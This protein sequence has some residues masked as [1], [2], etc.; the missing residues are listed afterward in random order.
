MFWVAGTAFPGS[1]ARAVLLFFPMTL[2]RA[3]SAQ[4]AEADTGPIVKGL[5]CQ[6]QKSGLPPESLGATDQISMSERS[7]WL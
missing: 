2:V 6:V 1:E 3:R 5:A 4:G 7:L